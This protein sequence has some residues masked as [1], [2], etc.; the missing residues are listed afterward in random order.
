MMFG[1]TTSFS[2]VTAW[3]PGIELVSPAP[4]AQAPLGIEIDWK[5]LEERRDKQ[6]ASDYAFIDT[7]QWIQE[8]D[9]YMIGTPAD[10]ETYRFLEE[11]RL[12]YARNVKLIKP[13]AY[14]VWGSWALLGI[15]G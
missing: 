8:C 6:I 11:Q 4:Q 14:A 10:E 7:Y 2:P 15:K 12:R 9:K 1:S 13:I 5:F 3:K